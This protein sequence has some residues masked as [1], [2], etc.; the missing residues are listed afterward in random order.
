MIP[1]KSL[2]RKQALVA[3]EIDPRLGPHDLGDEVLADR[4]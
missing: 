2:G 1:G 3:D 4:S